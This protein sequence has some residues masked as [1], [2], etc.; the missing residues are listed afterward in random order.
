MVDFTLEKEYERSIDGIAEKKNIVK[1]PSH[2]EVSA[3]HERKDI[4]VTDEMRQHDD[5]I[6]ND[7]D[8]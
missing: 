8:F 7:P 5:D 4:E 3:A 1:M 2:L 6:M